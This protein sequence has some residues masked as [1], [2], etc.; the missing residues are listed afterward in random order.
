MR[1]ALL[2]A[3]LAAAVVG[4]AFGCSGKEAKDKAAS[5]ADTA[6]RQP[7]SFSTF[8][9]SRDGKVYKMVEVGEQT[10]M[11][12]NLNYAAEGSRCYGEGVK[13]HW[14]DTQKLSPDDVQAKCAKYG[15]LYDWETAKKACPAGTHLSTD[16]EWTTL[17]YYAGGWETAGKKL[18]LSTYW[19]SDGEVPAST[20]EYGFS[21]LIGGYGGYGKTRD[22]SRGDLFYTI[23]GGFWWSATGIDADLALM[24]RMNYHDDKVYRN[25]NIKT[26]LFSIRCVADKEAQK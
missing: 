16:R 25:S 3:A 8:T 14:K 11:A 9:D 10:W 1:K 24:R 20:N 23:H 4:G 21:A 18:K 15:R 22:G 26:N 5:A 6:A 19:E 12:E 17:V 13:V 7:P 2:M